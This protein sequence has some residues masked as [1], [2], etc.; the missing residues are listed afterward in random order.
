MNSEINKETELLKEENQLLKEELELL[1]A[2]NKLLEFDKLR[3]DAILG[4]VP[5]VLWSADKNGIFTSSVGLGLD[6]L[7]LKQGQVVGTSLFDI[8]GEF[9]DIVNSHQKT[10]DGYESTYDFEMKGIQYV[11]KG[12]SLQGVFFDAKIVPIIDGDGVVTGLIG[13]ARNVSHLKSVETTLDNLPISVWQEDFSA[14]KHYLD[15]LELP[16]DVSMKTYLD[17]NPEIVRECLQLIKIIDVN[18]YSLILYGAENKSDLLDNLGIILSDPNLE[19]FKKELIAIFNKESN[20]S[21]ELKQRKLNGTEMDVVLNWYIPEQYQS[22]LERVYLTIQDVTDKIKNEALLRQSQKMEA[23]GRLAGGITHDFR[24]IMSVISLNADYLLTSLP[25]QDTLKTEVFEIQKSV[26]LANSITRQLLT[27]SKNQKSDFIAFNPTE[28]ILKLKDWLNRLLGSQFELSVNIKNNDIDI[29]A[30]SSM[31]EQVLINLIS[32][33]KDAMPEG[34]EIKVVL[35][36]VSINNTEYICDECKYGFGHELNEIYLDK[37]VVNGNYFSIH[38][39]DTGSGID[40]E[41]V[42]YIFEPFFTTKNP[43]KGTGLGLSTVYGIINDFSGYIGV[44]STVNKGT[45]FHILI[46]VVS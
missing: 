37:E 11:E 28:V 12:I 45:T 23:I 4:H 8:Y 26:K 27:F 17:N 18:L 44:T 41:S 43:G 5:I 30:N 35:D 34:G 39:Q 2:K 29:F 33:S 25:A 7:G 38:L 6:I 40:E 20:F 3:L 32:N 22:S 21:I 10:L 36:K 14:V 13:V 19:D 15:D 9:P 46:P 42:K 16:V 24:N 1:K 31:L